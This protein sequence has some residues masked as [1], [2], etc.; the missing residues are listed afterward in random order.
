MC[1]SDR[2]P[3]DSPHSGEGGQR[4]RG[5]GF[6]RSWD[7][8]ANTQTVRGAYSCCA[9]GV[10]LNRFLKVPVCSTDSVMKTLFGR[11]LR[12]RPHT[13]RGTHD[14]GT[15]DRGTHDRGMHVVAPA[16][17]TRGHIGASAETSAGP[18][19]A[20]R[21]PRGLPA[22]HASYRAGGRW[23]VSLHALLARGAPPPPSTSSL[24]TAD[25][26]GGP[27]AGTAFAA[28]QGFVAQEDIESVSGMTKCAWP[29]WWV[30]RY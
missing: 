25:D 3:H 2:S 11:Y 1:G 9:L 4:A 23:H 10:P 16:R 24:A 30:A 28:L 19:P 15:H 5:W 17:G 20:P 14:R 21:A 13:D 12:A 22:L 6:G 7:S 29:T 8:H 27:A 18:G 26:R